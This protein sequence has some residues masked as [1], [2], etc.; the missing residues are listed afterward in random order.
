MYLTVSFAYGQE[1]AS[2]VSS[3]ETVEDINNACDCLDRWLMAL[4]RVLFE[5]REKTAQQQQE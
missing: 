2:F 1:D 3:L 4:D 5:A